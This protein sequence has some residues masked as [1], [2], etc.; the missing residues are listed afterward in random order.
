MFIG[1]GELLAWKK[2]NVFFLRERNFFVLWNIW[3]E[4]ESPFEFSFANISIAYFII[5]RND[6]PIV[7]MGADSKYKQQF[8]L[9]YR[10]AICKQK[11]R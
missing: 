5:A 8:L 1:S 4:Q 2:F 7:Y 9:N 10:F 6:L 11:Y 3:C